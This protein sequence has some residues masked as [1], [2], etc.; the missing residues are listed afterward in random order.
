MGDV[1]F[2]VR[3]ARHVGGDQAFEVAVEAFCADQ[4]RMRSWLAGL[5]VPGDGRNGNAVTD[6]GG[7]GD[8][9]G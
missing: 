9:Q 2:P 7:I 6:D 3:T 1:A 4:A 8:G 5:P